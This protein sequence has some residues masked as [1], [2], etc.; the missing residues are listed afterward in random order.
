MADLLGDRSAAL[1]AGPD[2]R[3]DRAGALG[4]E[5]GADRRD[6]SAGPEPAHADGGADSL[7]FALQARRAG[8]H[9]RHALGYDTDGGALSPGPALLH[10]RA[11]GWRREG[12]T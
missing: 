11:D 10:P 3:G 7:Q 12:M 8:G 6:L 9:G 2:H 4:L 5:R 1:G